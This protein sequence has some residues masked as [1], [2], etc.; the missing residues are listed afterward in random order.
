[1]KLTPLHL[2]KDQ[3]T[4]V[5]ALP[6]VELTGQTVLLTGANTG[7][8]YEAAKHFAGLK[9][10]KLVVT[11]RTEEKGVH[12]VARESFSNELIFIGC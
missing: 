6:Q 4:P 10:G 8:G 3:C 9:P 1:M 7:L 12:T 2:L 5:P 11:T